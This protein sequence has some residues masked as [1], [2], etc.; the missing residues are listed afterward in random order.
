MTLDDFN[1]K[2]K[3]WPGIN[4]KKNSACRILRLRRVALATSSFPPQCDPRGAFCCIGNKVSYATKKSVHLILK[5]ENLSIKC[6][7]FFV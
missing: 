3:R 7:D 2:S 4:I 1:L 5:N 6:A